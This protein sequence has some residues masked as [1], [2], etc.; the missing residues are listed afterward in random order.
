MTTTP[1]TLVKY[2][3]MTGVELDLE[4]AKKYHQLYRSASDRGLD[5]NLS[6]S[7]VKALLR[8]KRCAYSGKEMVKGLVVQRGRGQSPNAL[9]IDRKNPNMGYVKG[10]VV[11]CTHIAN[12][13]KN[14]LEVGDVKQFKMMKKLLGVLEESGYSGRE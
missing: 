4:V 9:T 8:R 5:F 6:L 12:Q 2:S 1:T 10:N 3:D 13:L 14:T 7:D 11:S